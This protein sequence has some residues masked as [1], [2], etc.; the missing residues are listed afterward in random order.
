[1]SEKT[2]K[3]VVDTNILISSLI[4]P[5]DQFQALF[6]LVEKNKVILAFSW[7]TLEEFLI[8][9]ARPKIRKLTKMEG[10]EIAVFTDLLISKALFVEPYDKIKICRDPFDNKFIETAA[11]AKASYIVTGDKDLLEIKEYH[12]I[13]IIKLSGFLGLLSG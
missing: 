13:E 3:V 12:G 8:T 2:P 6:D 4:K 1:M 5:S 7:H 11:V 9:L 10:K